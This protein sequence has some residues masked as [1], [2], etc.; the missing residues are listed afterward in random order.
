MTKLSFLGCI[1]LLFGAGISG[2]SAQD[3]AVLFGICKDSLTSTELGSAT[4][5]AGERGVATDIV[6][7]AY[8]L[9]LAA[10]KHTIEI[11]YVGYNSRTIE[12]ELAAG[13]ER[14]MDILLSETATL[15]KVAT[16]TSSKFAKALSD[17]TV[18]MEIIQPD[19]MKNR[20]TVAVNEVLGAVPGVNMIDDQ[21]DIRGGAGYAQGTGGRV[22]MLMDDMPIMQADAGL[23]NWRDL[24][25]ENV[26]QIEVLKGAAS[27]LYGSAA[28]NGI[29]NI[30]T[31][32]PTDKPFT[33]IS[34]FHTSYGAPRDTLNKWWNKT[35]APYE[36]GVQIGHRQ[37]L[38]E[39]LDLVSGFNIYSNQSY[40]RGSGLD[41]TP[42]YDHKVRATVNLRY[43]LSDRLSVSLNTNFNTGRQNRHLFWTRQM[44]Q[45]LYEADPTS[46]P[47]RGTNTRITIDPSVT[48]FDKHQNR[49]KLLS[50]FYY[51]QNDNAN[52]QSNR[53]KFFY[54]EY[55]FQR[56]FENLQGLELSAGIVGSNTNVTAD[57][58]GSETFGITN[59]AAY[60]QLEKNFIERLNVSFGFR[61]ELNH[62]TAPDSITFGFRQIAAGDTTEGRPVIRLGLNYKLTEGT[63]L[64]ASFGQAYRFPT[65]LEKFVS[66]SAG[67]GLRV[68]PNP[69]LTS[70]SGWSAEIGIKQG[71]K[72]GEWQGFADIAG[73]WT[74]YFNMT[75]F[76]ANGS[77]FGFWVQNV[78]D[79]RI[80]GIDGSI[81]GQG[82][83]GKV[84]IDLLTG[85]TY[86]NPVFQ[87]FDSLAQ[88]SSSNEENVLKYRFRH[89]FKFDGQASFKGFGVGASLMYF[90]FMEAIDSYLDDPINYPTI[91]AFRENHA[92]GT[93]LLMGRV[94][95]SYKNARLSLLV[96]NLMNTE[97]SVRPG[98]LEAPRNLS[99]RA[100]F[101]F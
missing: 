50:R 61:Y 67:G 39:K 77:I 81:A 52:L 62:L 38:T 84:K 37:K 22:L 85:Y 55:Q 23:T 14:E 65:I 33:S 101:T 88:E 94:S 8:R 58:Y 3:K 71:F 27:A 9:E 66:T 43:R 75:E 26:A 2:L 97:F 25:T 21:V 80:R 28:M 49:H 96:N 79:T 68:Y 30:R 93:W 70:E 91:P 18:S 4:V 44:G 90:S 5:R 86:I 64:R 74:E 59:A 60:L 57:V 13:E 47:I 56:R 6:T 76:Q 1:C 98:V 87:N 69:Y 100:D 20:N 16:V 41:T 31:A 42:N 40:I 72:I 48:Y 17:V 53:S 34:V 92:D 11:S 46:I 78:G 19:L 24:P 95:Y 32:Y 35:N 36:A 51:I 63:F 83:I 99:V 10:G 45:S 89:T 12:L 73:F 7:G 29:I 15:L 82:N 54:G